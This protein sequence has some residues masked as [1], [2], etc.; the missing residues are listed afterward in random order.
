[1]SYKVLKAELD[2]LNGGKKNNLQDALILETAMRDGYVL[3]TADFH[4]YQVA[5]VHPVAYWYRTKGER[6]LKTFEKISANR[7]E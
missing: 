4:M 2:A 6:R 7:A 3:L 5:T 1:M